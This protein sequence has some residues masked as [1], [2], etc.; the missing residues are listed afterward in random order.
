MCVTLD[1]NTGADMLHTSWFKKT[2]YFSQCPPVFLCI[3]PCIDLC[4]I[5][6]ISM[7]ICVCTFLCVNLCINLRVCVCG[8][9][10]CVS[11]SLSDRAL[12]FRGRL[13]QE[14]REAMFVVSLSC[15]T[16]FKSVF[17]IASACGQRN[18]EPS[19]RRLRFCRGAASAESPRSI[20]PRTNL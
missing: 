19:R 12:R 14:P 2:K 1:R 16:K 5:Y 17:R 6:C 18:S 20:C 8:V 10:A 7:C 15:D 11:S 3:C 13:D 9:R 4:F